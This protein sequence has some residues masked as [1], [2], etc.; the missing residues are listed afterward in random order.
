[1]LFVP[2]SIPNTQIPCDHNVE[3]TCQT[4]WYIKLLDGFKRLIKK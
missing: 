1:M 3:F 4:L 2:R